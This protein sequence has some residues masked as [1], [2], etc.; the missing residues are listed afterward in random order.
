MP[1]REV[2]VQT[3]ISLA[4]AAD[5]P[6]R[7]FLSLDDSLTDKDNGSHRLQAVDWHFDHTRSWPGRPMYTKR[8]VYVMVRLTVGDV[9]FTVDMVPYLRAKTVRRLNRARRKGEK[10]A[11]RTKIQIARAMLEA[12]APLLPEGYQ[13][14]LL[15]DSW[16]AAA[17]FIKWC[18]SQDWH[19]IC[20]LKSN[21][22]LDGVQVRH[23]DPRLKHRRHTRV[24]VPAADEEPPRYYLV[25][26]LT[27]KL[28]TLPDTVRVFMSRR[29]N[30]D[31]RLRYYGC[32]NP[33]LSA[34]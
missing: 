6:E 10:L 2:L 14:Y 18:R 32:T 9:S 34:H 15:C 27:G 28:S 3:A 23:H 4:E 7:V 29:H 16:Y 20:R 22:L 5:A 1:L 26:S 12:V 33:S 8:T 13:V 21:R 24:R 30:R 17:A 25:R 31:K 11:L 19:V